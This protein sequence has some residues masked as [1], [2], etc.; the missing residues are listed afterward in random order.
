[1]EDLQKRIGE[2]EEEVSKLPI[3]YLSMKNIHGR[4]QCYLQWTENG[5]KKSKYVD[6]ETAAILAK[7]I[8]RRRTLQQEIK[9]L[10]AMLPKEKKT[11]IRK[12][13]SFKT[14]VLT[15]QQ[16]YDLVQPVTE[17]RKR[18]CY[19]E[20]E[21]YLYGENIGKVL[22]LFGLRRTGKTT[23][24]RQAI[25][26]MTEDNFAK[27]AYIQITGGDTLP[28]VNRDLRMLA[29]AGYRYVFLDE[30]TLL[31]DFIEG[32]ALFS[33]IYAASGM[34]IILSGTDS[35]GFVFSEDEQ[36]YDRCIL[37][38]TTFIP[39]REFDQVLGIHGIDEYIRYGGTMSLGGKNYNEAVT[40]GSK[41]KADDYV[42]TA[43]ARNIQH[44]LRYYQDEG[45]FRNL[46]DLYERG[47]LTSAINRIVEDIN[48]RFTIEILTRDFISH[49][50]GIS[51][52]NL[53]HDRDHPTDILSRIDVKSFTDGLRKTLDILNKSEQT[54]VI[55]DAHRTEI[56]EYL[57]LLDLTKDVA[58]EFIP[59]RNQKEY[60][61]VI[62][63]P[64]LRYAQ[65][66]ALVRQL[67]QDEVF[68]N[69]SATDLVWI[70][71]RILDEIRGRMMED[72]VLLE[73]KMAFPKKNVFK[74]QFSVGEF[75][76]VVAD[77]ESISC[78]I[79]E[80]KHSMKAMSEQ[81]RHL[82]DEEKCAATAFRYGDI[83]KK[84]VL[85]RGEDMQDGEIEFKN[86][87][88]YLKELPAG[89]D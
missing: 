66:E 77:P 78:E 25:A 37:I 29:D 75:D 23:L 47:E 83:K 41:Q 9:T 65:A 8:V 28:A 53:L 17:L 2:L 54:I 79:Y 12:P 89:S 46:Q 24:V 31:K 71:S 60:R 68:Q 50:L 5:K 82:V 59:V 55:T 30:I 7:Q 40:F 11:P 35:L 33:D 63:Q 70:I 49:D 22:I 1:M 72:I 42:D 62:A 86:V 26:S 16:L 64:G 19:T 34:K 15:G 3:G 4:V 32:A 10:K 56:K 76:M 45:H 69:L 27:T 84:C 38:H 20:I 73:T 80:I 87:E 43:I 85:Y 51:N 88:S 36:L 18:S 74:L 61:T 81:Y 57:D 58:I 13:K 6:D 39:Y 44:S 48:H 52:R 21:Q 67:M 14:N